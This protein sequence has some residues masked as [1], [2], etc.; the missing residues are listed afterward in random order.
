MSAGMIPTAISITGDSAWRA[1]MG[2]VVIGAESPADSGTASS[3]P[4]VL[5]PTVRTAAMAKDGERR[6]LRNLIQT[7]AAINPGNSGGPVLDRRGIAVRA[8]THCAMPLLQHL[9][10]GT[11]GD[12]VFQIASEGGHSG[13]VALDR[14]PRPRRRTVRGQRRR[15]DQRR[16][17]ASRRD[18]R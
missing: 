5:K 12:T 1:P 4:D 2:V 16:A 11:V 14:S 13:R 18:A 7:D 10:V 8:G 15:R 3:S 17:P 6:R 9:D